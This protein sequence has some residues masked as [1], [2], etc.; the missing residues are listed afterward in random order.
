MFLFYVKIFME[1]LMKN[2]CK[3]FKVLVLDVIEIVVVFGGL[4]MFVVGIFLF[5]ESIK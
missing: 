3:V 5:V 4:F 1:N 2:K